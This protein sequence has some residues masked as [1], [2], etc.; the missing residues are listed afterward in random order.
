MAMT[1]KQ[2]KHM[3]K[4]RAAKVAK[5]AE[6]AQAAVDADNPIGEFEDGVSVDDMAPA[7]VAARARVRR[8]AAVKQAEPV[9]RPVG[10]PRIAQPKADYEPDPPRRTRHQLDPE[11]E[12]RAA[13]VGVGGRI[14][15]RARVDPTVRRDLPRDPNTGRVVVVRDGKTYTRRH[16]NVGD[17]FHVDAAD[18]PDGMS[19]QWIAVTVAGAEQRNSLAQFQQNGWESV[20]MSRYPGRYG[21]EKTAGKANH[22][23][24]LIYGL[25]LCERPIELTIEA[26]EEEIGAARQL[27]RTR[28]KPFTPKRPEAR[29]RR[30]TE[31]RAK[32]TVEGM[33]PDIGRPSYQLDVD[34]G[35]G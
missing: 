23:P 8:Q 24:I 9:K 10:R 20:P 16:T 31:P 26:R 35:L 4:M 18:I 12:A 34:D 11:M 22:E 7:S 33:P 15:M 29:M 17:K 5:R 1:P 32:R 30:G 3:E 28:N 21:P 25:M 13:R 19:Y 27:I 6:A 14:P 2:R